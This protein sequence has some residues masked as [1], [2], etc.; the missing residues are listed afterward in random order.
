M[1]GRPGLGTSH[2]FHE[3]PGAQA[4]EAPPRNPRVPEEWSHPVLIFGVTRTF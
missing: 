1:V 2:L 4:E 3:P